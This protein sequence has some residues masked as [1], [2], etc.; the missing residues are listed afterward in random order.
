MNG[1]HLLPPLHRSF[2]RKTID[3]DLMLYLRILLHFPATESSSTKI[4]FQNWLYG[5]VE[6]K[7][8]DDLVFDSKVRNI[9]F[10]R[11]QSFLIVAGS[12]GRKTDLGWARFRSR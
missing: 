2:M 3:S 1:I 10:G 4:D 5:A 9:E 8:W 6:A 12:I 7:R 11:V